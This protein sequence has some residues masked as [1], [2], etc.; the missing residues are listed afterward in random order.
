VTVTTTPVRAG[1]WLAEAVRVAGRRLAPVGVAVVAIL[2][3][4]TL[5]LQV[6]GI[7]RV[8]GKTPWDVF[9][10][11]F[12]LPAA[13]QNRALV[14]GDLGVTLVDAGV[15]YVFGLLAAT[16][17]AIGFVL[18]RPVEQAFMP[19]ATLLRSVP[20]VALT[21]LIVLAFGR[22]LTATGVIGGIVVFFPSLVTTVLGLRSASPWALDLVA[23]YGGGRLTR[24]RRVMLPSAVPALFASARLAVPGAMIGALMAEWLATGRGSG[25][26]MI[27]AVGGFRY[28][29]MWASVV[30][31]TGASIV[32]Y[33]V[34][35]IVESLVVARMGLAGADTT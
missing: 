10:W 2:V 21:P 16:A 6:F 28:I 18:S 17:V 19:L 3:L 31:V 29:E 13:P 30:V 1:S 7:R 27:K 9:S 11:L 25:A 15:G 33:A 12:L 22:N 32:I 35:G 8:I 34:V 23:A 26:T 5:F 4:W 14:F 24:L 20:L